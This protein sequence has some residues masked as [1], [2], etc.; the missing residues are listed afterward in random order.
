MEPGPITSNKVFLHQATRTYVDV[1]RSQ[2]FKKVKQ[3]EG[4]RRQTISRTFSLN[5][6]RLGKKKRV[7]SSW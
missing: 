4:K 6:T 1:W 7:K 5:Q 3:R 2:L